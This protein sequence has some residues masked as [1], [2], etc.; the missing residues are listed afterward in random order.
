MHIVIVSYSSQMFK[1][2]PKSI[3]TNGTR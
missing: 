2:Y 1:W 3:V